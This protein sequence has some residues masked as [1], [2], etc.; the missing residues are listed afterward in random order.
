MI[1]RLGRLNGVYEGRYEGPRDAVFVNG[2][3]KRKVMEGALG[4]EKAQGPEGEG[5]GEKL[6]PLS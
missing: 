2:R 4:D 1:E 5:E 6:H 3:A